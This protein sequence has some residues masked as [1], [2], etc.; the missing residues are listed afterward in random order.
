MPKLNRQSLGSTASHAARAVLGATVVFAILWASIPSSAFAPGPLCTLACCAGRAPHAAGSCMDGSCHANVLA[1]R[2]TIHIHRE[3]PVP[4]SERLCGLQKLTARASFW[5]RLWAPG[6]HSDSIT[7]SEHSASRI[8]SGRANISS[9]TLRKPCESDCGAG[10]VSS[11]NQRRP[12]ESAAHANA[13]RTR[14]LSNRGWLAAA[15]TCIYA[16]EAIRW[17]ANPR[18]PPAPR[19]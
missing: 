6:D 1:H 4:Q 5:S 12:R 2:K 14:P 8:A 18:A 11:T 9:S 16:R 19:S 15:N 17:Q 13:E 7:D 10:S 3:S